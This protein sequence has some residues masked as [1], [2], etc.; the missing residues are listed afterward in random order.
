MIVKYFSTGQRPQRRWRTAFTAIRFL[1]TISH[2]ANKVPKETSV[3]HFA[4]DISS[5]DHDT[6]YHV[7]SHLN[8]VARKTLINMVKEKSI[9]LLN[10]L[11]GVQ[12]VATILG[13]NVK[14]GISDCENDLLHRR[15]VFGANTYPKPPRRTFLGFSLAALKGSTMIILLVC[16]VLSLGFSFEQ[17]SESKHGYSR[18][19]DDVSNIVAVFL[20]VALCAGANFWLSNESREVSY[21]SDDIKVQVVRNG[22]HF[23]VSIFDIVVGDVVSLRIGDKIPANGLLLEGFCLQVE[24]SNNGGE[25]DNIISVDVSRNP[26]LLSGAKVIDGLGFMIVTSVG[27]DTLWG[28]IMSSANIDLEETPLQESLHKLTSCIGKAGLA[29]AMMIFMVLLFNNTQKSFSEMLRAMVGFLNSSMTVLNLAIPEGL[30]LAV[31]LTLAYS[32]K[33]MKDENVMARKLSSFE[34]M[35]SVTTICSNKTGTLT[36]NQMKVAELW[37]GEEAF[38]GGSL[39]EIEPGVSKL[40]KEGLALNNTC[41]V[42]E[43]NAGSTLEISGSPTEKAIL[44]WGATCL[45]MDIKEIKQDCQVIDVKAFNSERKR[46]GILMRKANEKAIHTHWKGG[47]EIILPM[48]SYYYERN[49]TVKDMNGE[50][51]MELEAIIERMSAKGLRSIAFGHRKVVEQNDQVYEKLEQSGLTLLG[52]AGLENPCRLGVKEAI[53]LCKEAKVN[54]KMITGDNVY[55]ATAVAIECGILNG[56]EE[57]AKVVVEGEQFRNYSVEERMKRID[58]I[59]VM[60]RSSPLDKLLMVQCLQ[61]KGH[62]VAVTG[63]GSSDV[64][65]LTKADVVF[66]M[67][68]Q[69]TVAAKEN[70]DIVMLDD[71][72]TSI[73]RLLSW[74]RCFLSN[75]HNFIQFQL[76]VNIAAFVFNFIAAV[77]CSEAPLTAAQVLWLNLLVDIL[78]VFAFSTNQ[79]T[80]DLM[81]NPPADKQELLISYSM[82]K[83]LLVQALYQAAILLTLQ[84]KGSIIFRMTKNVKKTVIFNTFALCQVFNVFNARVSEKNKRLEGIVKNKVFLMAIGGVVFLQVMM[85]E[86]LNK[87]ANTEKLSLTQ[88]CACIGVAAL[89]WLVGWVCQLK[90]NACS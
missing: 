7:F 64:P 63:N 89:S 78:G 42:G 24:E 85:V 71:S 68:I 81:R 80:D 69:G 53:N 82:W 4:I 90:S 62:V 33:R 43:Q 30:P 47:A 10:E 31:T 72:F 15:N 38:G 58:R 67:G 11:G 16:A 13:S 40:L 87:V 57:T 14:E 8:D 27:M 52:I 12:R 25:L 84:L 18:W 46:S 23:L 66:S 79:P 88:W 48:C 39:I 44:E 3:S 5:N 75:I 29:V 59:R 9:E 60:A 35:A 2:F 70:A 34:T 21:A 50:E 36:L 6:P 32:M 73:A 65:T 51:R 20:V 1:R 61:R 22:R 74:G 55:T 54:V 77:Y 45:G 56:E 76:T 37:I 17:Q 83:N 49:G 28:E 19:Y 26:F 86:A 41:I